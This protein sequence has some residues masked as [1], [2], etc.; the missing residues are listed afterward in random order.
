MSQSALESFGAYQRALKLFDCVVVDMALLRTDPRCYRLISQQVGSADSIS[1]NIEEGYGRLSRAEY[2]RFLD[3]ARGSARETRG[4]YKRMK[5]WLPE[6]IVAARVALVDEVIGILTASI[7][8]LRES[9]DGGR[10]QTRVARE[11]L[12]EY[13]SDSAPSTRDP[14]HAADESE[15]S[16]EAPSCSQLPTFEN[17]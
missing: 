11:E 10:G 1:A 5:H 12:V 2:V 17:S 9:L 3:I 13:G 4:R 6:D 7:E 15:T 8:R 14:R 16:G